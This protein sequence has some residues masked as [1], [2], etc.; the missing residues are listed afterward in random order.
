MLSLRKLVNSINESEP[1]VIRK[2]IYVSDLLEEESESVLGKFS[3][4][5]VDEV[6]DAYGVVITDTLLRIFSFTDQHI[7]LECRRNQENGAWDPI[8]CTEAINRGDLIKLSS[9][10]RLAIVLGD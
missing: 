6:P 10:L 2:H 1:E 8:V 3:L 7:M 9:Q 4:V 5:Y